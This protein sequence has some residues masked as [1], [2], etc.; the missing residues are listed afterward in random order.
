MSWICYSCEENVFGTPKESSYSFGE[1][2]SGTMRISDF[3]IGL[4]LLEG[5]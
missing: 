1:D 4:V 3:R 5:H 2:R